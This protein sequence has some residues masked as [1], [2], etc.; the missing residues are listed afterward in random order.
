MTIDD[1]D[2]AVVAKAASEQGTGS[3]TMMFRVN[4]AAVYARGGAM[5]PM[6]LMN[7][8]LSAQAHRR[9]VE[10]AAEGNFNILRIWGG[11][12]FMPPAFYEACDDFGIMLYHDMQF[13]GKAGAV[14]F[15]RIVEGEI[16]HNVK[17]LS[18]HPSIVFWDGCNECK[19]FYA[20]WQ[21]VMPAVASFDTSRPIWPSSPANGWVTGVDRLSSRP[22][23]QRQI[24][25][26]H[27]RGPGVGGYPWAQE[28][29]GP[30]T[31]FMRSVN[32]WTMPHAIPASVQIGGMGGGNDPSAVPS[33]TGPGQEGWAKSE[34]GANSWPSF[35]GISAQLP[36]DQWSLDSA[37]AKYRNWNVSIIVSAFF[38]RPAEVAMHEVG[39]LPF[40]RQLYQ[41]LIAQ[42]LYLK[43]MIEAWRTTNMMITLWW[44]YN[45]MW[46]TGGWGSVEYGAAVPGQIVGGRWKPLHYE[47][48]R[49]ARRADQT[50]S[51]SVWRA[52][53]TP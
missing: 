49:S 8:R 11:A 3:L 27:W 33:F 20:W 37:A 9:V 5:V 24:P 29:H 10:S 53:L 17:R 4:G 43:T 28:S 47:M 34:F 26:N 45:E 41:S 46:P 6:D 42:Q 23:G 44:M 16:E 13:D 32:N 30:Y 18:H 31:G 40:K 48:K 50:A 14:T 21:H 35:E 36:E 2:P 19:T 22:N 15:S 39:E 12:V 52:L 38:G 51:W 25:N 1:T 7:G